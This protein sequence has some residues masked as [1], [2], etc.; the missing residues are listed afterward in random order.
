MLKYKSYTGIIEY[1]EQGKIFTG[2][3]VGLK[4]VIT[5]QGRTPQE[6]EDS[7]HTSVDLY[8]QMCREDG[9]T[10]EKPYSGKFNLRL[11]QTLHREIAARAAVASISLNEWVNEAIRK[12]L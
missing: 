3:V 2:E 12:A 9:I 1:D 4:T 6:L 11:D 5:F 7:F 8:M 10:P